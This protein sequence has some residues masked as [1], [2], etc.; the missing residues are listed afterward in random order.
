MA[1]LDGDGTE[2]KIYYDINQLLINGED[3]SWVLGEDVFDFEP[4]HEH[5]IIADIDAADPARQIVIITTG[6]SEDYAL[7]FYS[8]ADG[9]LIELGDAP[10]FIEELATT[11]DGAG[12]IYGTRPLTVLQT[13]F[14]PARWK[15]ED[16]QV[17]LDPYDLY[18]PFAPSDLPPVVLK[19]E[20][21]I[22]E[23]RGDDSPS[24]TMLPQ[25]VQFIAT[26]NE[27]WVQIEAGDGTSGWFKVTGDHI[28][29]LDKDAREVFDN[30]FSAG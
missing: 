1:D 15:L 8:Y 10:I 23:H 6:P 7:H 17:T 5:L 29:D 24:G 4:H 19:V 25:A 22:Y 30:L 3:L 21:P 16:G 12:H 28:V 13:W 26:D 20:L 2:E 14:A 27:E 18:Y 9:R 11:F